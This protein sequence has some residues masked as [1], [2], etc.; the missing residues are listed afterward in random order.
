MTLAEEDDLTVLVEVIKV[1]GFRDVDGLTGAAKMGA[2]VAGA[3]GDVDL[4]GETTGGVIGEGA[5]EVA[6]FVVCVL[7]LL[8]V[9]ETYLEVVREDDGGC[10]TTG[11]AGRTDPPR[12]ARAL[13]KTSGADQAC[14]ISQNITPPKLVNFLQY[15]ITSANFSPEM[16]P[17]PEA[18]GAEGT[19]TMTLTLGFFDCLAQFCQVSKLNPGCL[20]TPDTNALALQCGLL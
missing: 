12:A 3:G 7:A 10:W 16:N 18:P 13:V 17:L 2:T 9:F 15:A 11:A 6:A 1:V 8:V 20:S 5:L 4:T 19:P 14:D